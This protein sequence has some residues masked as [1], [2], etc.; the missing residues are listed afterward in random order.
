MN[1]PLGRDTAIECDTELSKPIQIVDLFA[2]PGGLGEGFA[3]S[4][5]G[6]RFEI[7]VSAEMNPIARETLKLRAFYRLLKKKILTG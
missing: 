4:G 5:G 7:L 1:L 3:S 2:G 6:S